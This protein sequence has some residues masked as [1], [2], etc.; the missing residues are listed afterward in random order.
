MK[1]TLLISF[2][3]SVFFTADAKHVTGGEMIYDFI[4]ATATT[5]TYRIT[6]QLFRDQLCDAQTNCSPMPPSVRIG[7][8]NRDNNSL[9]GNYY[10]L[11]LSSLTSVPPGGVPACITNPPTLDYK[12]G[13]YVFTITL[14]NNINGYTAA[15][16]TCCRI[17][18]LGN[19]GNM[20]GATYTADLP[21]SSLAA[22]V[23]DNSPRFAQGISVVCFN[24]YF[25]LDFSATDADGDQLVYSFCSGFGGGASSTSAPFDASPP[26]Y[27][28][29][30]YTGGFSGS[31]PLGSSALINSQTGIISGIAP[32]AGKYVVSVC[33]SSYRNGVF[34]AVHRKDFIITVAPCDL[35]GVELEPN[36][37]TC[38]GFSYS[39]QNLLSSPL[40]LTSYW[41]FGD[42]GSGANNISLA[43]NPTHTYTDTGVYTLKLVVNRGNSCSDSAYAFVKVYPGYF[44][45]LD[46]NSPR[47]KGSSVQ[48]SDQ[49]TANYG[50]PNSWKWN[51][52]DPNSTADTS[53]LQNPVYT[54]NTPGTYVSTLTVG[55]S[56]GCIATVTD[57]VF[58][59][60]KP[61]FTTSNDTLICSVDNVQLFASGPSTCCVT[62]SPN[63]NINDVNSFTP[64]VAPDVTTTYS[65]SYTDN[66]GC[67]A[68]GSVT[69]NVVDTVTLK[70]GNDTTIC[71]TDGISLS[72]AS[73][74]LRYTWTQFPAGSTLNDATLKNPVATPVAA[75]TSYYVTGRIGSCVDSDSIKI[76]TVPYPIPNAGPDQT[77][78][79]GASTSLQASG[80]ST[81]SWSPIAFLSSP[82]TAAT[83]VQS[84]T[85]SVDYTVSVTENMG[86]PKAVTD[87]VTVKVNRITADAGPRDTSVVRDQPLQLNGTGSSNYSWIG[88]PATQWLSS[89]TIANPV[90][91]PQ[92]DIT[93]VLTATDNIGCFDTDTITVR[94]YKVNPDLYVPSAFSPNGDGTNDIIKPLALG[95]RSVDAFR[96]YNRWGQ[97][98]FSTSQIGAGWNGKLAGADQ[99]AGTYIYYAEGTDFRNKKISRK[100]YVVLIR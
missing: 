2:F 4:S 20:E 9:V 81:Y 16:Q 74:A 91:M 76:A 25:T 77:I 11:N 22:T 98:L 56:K 1:Q 5:K 43:D 73:N 26:P 57:T 65:V 13:T 35:A 75:F 45:G 41:N 69:V 39:F 83:N 70:T 3:L 94:F 86:C 55:S 53:Q 48:F 51:F 27:G 60:E 12:V 10:D 49:T 95:L 97:L 85:I 54:Y 90:S 93:Y 15:Y 32:D 63:Y 29:L 19:V 87:V 23:P 59:L 89:T 44:P 7:V 42:P 72:L 31:A 24:K 18:G 82:G 30:S 58:I 100:G 92:D 33:V 46:N 37:I 36:Y 66:R 34:I 78:C 47:C 8:F 62:W 88:L 96:I 61:D 79:L 80:G 21:G 84:P 38:D 71:R 17:D 28:I 50:I 64:I 99:A 52:G 14:P 67:S 6:L 40:N 68:I